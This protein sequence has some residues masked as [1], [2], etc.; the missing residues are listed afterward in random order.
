MIYKPT[1][2][3]KNM[4]L[5]FQK[6]KLINELRK[7]K[8]KKVLVQLP[9]GIKQNAY[10]IK[11]LIEQMNIS[12]VF[13]GETCWGACALAINEAKKEK[14]DA[15]VHFGHSEFFKQNEIPVIYIEVIDQLNLIPLLEK[16]LPILEKYKT[17]GFS[18]SIQH[19]DDLKDILKFY[20]TQEKEV[21][22]S[23][24]I[25]NISY[26][27][28]ILGCQY[29]GLKSIQDKVDAFVILGNR[30]HAIGALL[31]VNKPVILLDVYNDEI[32]IF[33]NLKEKI[34]KQR[35]ISIQKFKD[36]KKI[37]VLIEIKSGQRFGSESL[38]IKK[39]ESSGKDFIIISIDE[40]T[41]E[42]LCNFY[43]IDAFVELACPRIAIDD[44]ANYD[45]P[46]LTFREAMCALGQITW[47][48]LIKEGLL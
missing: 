18:Y 42:K 14:C 29:E 40:I 26:E 23:K 28:Q 1:F 35:A 39:L 22:L 30:F 11:E 20:Q 32:E 36:A 43:D 41:N 7:L 24:K 44:Y 37:G 6:P 4:V 15:I 9:E 3:L 48:E 38:L 5:N 19:K 34:L 27:G 16:S 8:P 21:V 13:S 31:S 25:G 17:I 12:V 2:S 46:I 45:K 10:E 33:E 47:E